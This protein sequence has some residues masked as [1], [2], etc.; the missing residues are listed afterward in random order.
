[1]RIMDKPYEELGWDNYSGEAKWYT[2]RSKPI[3]SGDFLDVEELAEALSN[4]TLKRLVGEPLN[5]S[6]ANILAFTLNADSCAMGA[7]YGPYTPEE[8][9]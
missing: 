8:E 2:F 4:I 1:M 7:R 6:E 9:E 5:T 3:D